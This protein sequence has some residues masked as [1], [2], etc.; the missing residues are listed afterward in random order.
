MLIG[1][2]GKIGE[3]IYEFSRTTEIIGHPSIPPI[4]LPAFVSDSKIC[5]FGAGKNIWGESFYAC[6]FLWDANNQY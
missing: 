5:Q 1:C 2:N 3:N 4:F 6:D